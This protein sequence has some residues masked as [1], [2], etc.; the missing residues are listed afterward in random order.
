[1]LVSVWYWFAG[2]PVGL[3][4][5]SCLP[6]GTESPRYIL[7][8]REEN[9][10]KFKL[11]QIMAILMGKASNGKCVGHVSATFQKFGSLI[12]TSE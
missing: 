7:Q 12:D 9:R 4:V 8:L 6:Y 2:P 5:I 3:K 1:M 11:K 10:A